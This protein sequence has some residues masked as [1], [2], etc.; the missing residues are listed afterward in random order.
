MLRA[1]AIEETWQRTSS[2]HRLNLHLSAVGSDL[3]AV[4]GQ[5]TEEE[6]DGKKSSND[7]S[8]KSDA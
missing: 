6:S 1:V 8:M 2:I 3:Y 7:V 4:V 5:G